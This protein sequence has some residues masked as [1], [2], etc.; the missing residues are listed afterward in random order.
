MSATPLRRLVASDSTSEMKPEEAASVLA[1]PNPKGEHVSEEAIR[2]HAFW[3]WELA[4]KPSGDGVRFWL[5][6]EQELL[7]A[8]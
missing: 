6:A 3:R 2:L 5:E 1:E 7:Q 8:K 4:G